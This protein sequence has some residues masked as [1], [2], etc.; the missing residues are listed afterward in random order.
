MQSQ[1]FNVSGM[2]CAS[3]VGAIESSVKGV[4][5]VQSVSVNLLLKRANVQFEPTTTSPDAIAK[6]IDDVGYKAVPIRERKSTPGLVAVHFKNWT[7]NGAW[8]TFLW[9]WNEPF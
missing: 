4:E 7:Q 5:G 2:V 8:L 9:T 3:C 1:S 6:A